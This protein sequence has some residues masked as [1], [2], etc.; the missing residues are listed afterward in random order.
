MRASERLSPGPFIIARPSFSQS[1]SQSLVLPTSKKEP[2]ATDGRT[3]PPS[4]PTTPTK[5]TPRRCCRSLALSFCVEERDPKNKTVSSSSWS[6]MVVHS[7]YL[8]IPA[9]EKE[10][11][12]QAAETRTIAPVTRKA[13]LWWSQQD[14][15][16]ALIQKRSAGAGPQ[17]TKHEAIV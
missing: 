17:N 14:F 5:A 10:R 3:L 16:R 4:P 7:C 13:A 15:D 11:R 1:V 9:S 6:V 2:R 12:R 8:V